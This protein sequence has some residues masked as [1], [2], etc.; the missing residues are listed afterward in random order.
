MR[1]LDLTEHAYFSQVPPGLTLRRT[2]WFRPPQPRRVASR[3]ASPWTTPEVGRGLGLCPVAAG[4]GEATRGGLSRAAFSRGASRAGPRPG[5]QD[6]ERPFPGFPCPQVA[7]A[8]RLRGAQQGKRGDTVGLAPRPPPAGSLCSHARVAPSARSRAVVLSC[9][10]W[11][12]LSDPLRLLASSAPDL[13]PSHL[14]RLFSIPLSVKSV[15]FFQVFS[16]E[17]N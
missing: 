2:R 8:R 15:P 11:P 6:A 12:C 7:A 9:P 14:P 3:R 17:L 4:A 10:C 16:R 13:P 1:E 5:V